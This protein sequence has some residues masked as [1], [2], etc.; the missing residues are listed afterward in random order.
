MLKHINMPK[1]YSAFCC[2]LRPKVSK[3]SKLESIKDSPNSN[4]IDW[5]SLGEEFVVG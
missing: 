3:A 2:W 5:D 1:G 4:D